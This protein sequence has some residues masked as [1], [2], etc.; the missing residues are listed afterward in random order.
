M[1]HPD[2]RRGA[3]LRHTVDRCFLTRTQSETLSARISG[4]VYVYRHKFKLTI[5]YIDEKRAIFCEWNKP[6]N[7]VQVVQALKQVN[8]NH[9]FNKQRIRLHLYLYPTYGSNM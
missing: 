1:R 2:K 8:T 5:Y 4:L 7:P 6:Q 9:C 3:Y